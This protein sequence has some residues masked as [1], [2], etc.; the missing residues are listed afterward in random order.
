[1]ECKNK[2]GT[3]KRD[4]HVALSSALLRE[5]DTATVPAVPNAANN[6]V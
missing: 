6:N 2:K 3:K 5:E 4:R 1:V